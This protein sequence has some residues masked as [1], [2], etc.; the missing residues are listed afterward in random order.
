MEDNADFRE[1][2]GQWL[3][4]AGAVVSVARNG[5]EALLELET[6]PRPDVIV[7]DLHMP[8][9]DGCAFVSR[10][11]DA[12]GLGHIPVIAL[13]GSVSDS[14][15]MRTLEAGFSAH[16]RKPV[17]EESLQAQIRRVLGR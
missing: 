1:L 17:S 11:K 7:C 4:R 10:L 5:H 8:G 12:L 9:M 6:R 16:L 2:L 14:A 13:T 15:L 3:E